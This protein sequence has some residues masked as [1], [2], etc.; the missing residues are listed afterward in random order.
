ML[1]KPTYSEI[2]TMI[3]CKAD[4]IMSAYYG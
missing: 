4:L 1:Y 2:D 3:L